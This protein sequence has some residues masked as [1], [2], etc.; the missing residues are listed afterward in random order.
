MARSD[1]LVSL[2][3]AGSTGDK[4]VFRTTA[5]AIIAEER[6]KHHDVLADKL[7]HAIRSNGA[8][9]N[10]NGYHH[11]TSNRGRDYISEVV[12]RRRL[13]DLVLPPDIRRGAQQLIEEQRRADP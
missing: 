6:A 2:V 9:V 12:P 1:L 7:S 3:K 5:E 13:E 11:E 8:P 4:G 10:G